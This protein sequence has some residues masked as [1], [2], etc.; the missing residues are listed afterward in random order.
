MKTALGILL[1]AVT[2]LSGCNT[3]SVKP[4]PE[5]KLIGV[6]LMHGKGEMPGSLSLPTRTLREAGVL[7]V[8]PEMPWSR[9]RMY[10][11]SYED[12]ML[13]I[14]K[15]VQQLRAKGASKVFVG[16][17]SI[18]ANAALGYATRRDTISG[19]ILFAPGHVPGIPGF[20]AKVADG[21]NKARDMVA[22]GQGDEPSRF[23]DSN[24]GSSSTVSTTANIYLS[25][26][27]P[28]GPAVMSSNAAK[29]P[30]N[31]TLFCADGSRERRPR[32]QYVGQHLSP[33][34]RMEVISVN[35]GHG[36]V[37]DKA[38]PLVVEWLRTLDSP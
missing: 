9:N 29:V 37:P 10:A 32:C 28:E 22:K 20:A 18:G 23:S 5:G 8:T 11:K 27:A 26:F 4:L 36:D 24:Q 33:G 38:V 19:L 1:I 34:I 6:V 17:H 25:W 7:V 21:T 2:V 14:D 16:G 12:S 3:S 31:I 15:A 30:P 35:A 13:E